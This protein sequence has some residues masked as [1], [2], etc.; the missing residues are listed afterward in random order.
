MKIMKDEDVIDTEINAM[1]RDGCHE[2]DASDLLIS[3]KSSGQ[4]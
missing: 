1:Q 4:Q 3:S 2:I